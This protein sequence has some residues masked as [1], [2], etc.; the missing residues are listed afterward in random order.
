MSV[1]PRNWLTLAALLLC[2]CASVG[3][4]SLGIPGQ[5][6]IAFDEEGIEKPAEASDAS[7]AELQNFPSAMGRGAWVVRV[8]TDGEAP[9]TRWRHVE[10][11]ELLKLPADERPLFNEWL[12]H[13][14]PVVAGNAAIAL[15]RLGEGEPAQRLAATVRQPLSSLPVEQRM[16]MRCAAAEALGKVQADATV[17][18]TIRKLLAHF[19]QED[20]QVPPLQAELL[21]SLARHV[22]PDD[23]PL[24]AEALQSPKAEVQLAVI[25]CWPL[26]GRA[27]L[28]EEVAQLFST[29]DANLRSRALT[30]M[31]A[32]KDPAAFDMAQKGLSDQ[33]LEVRLAAIAA[34]GKIGTQDA[35]RQ[36]RELVTDRTERIRAEAVAALA[37]CHAWQPVLAAASDE[38][39][40]V[41]EAVAQGLAKFPPRDAQ[42]VALKLIEDQSS[43]VTARVIAAIEPWPLEQAGQVLVAAL[44]SP[45]ISVRKSAAEQLRK[46][47]EACPVFDPEASP[48]KREEQLAELQAAWTEQFAGA[49]AM[50]QSMTSEAEMLSEEASTLAA[51]ATPE[52]LAR[53]EEQLQQLADTELDAERRAEIEKQLASAGPELVAALTELRLERKMPVPESVYEHVLPQTESVFTLLERLQS[54]PLDERRRAAEELKKRI[55]AEPVGELALARLT[56][57]VV[58][59]QDAI[60]WVAIQTAL[61]ADQREP[62]VRLHQA[63]LG[64][65]AAEVRRRAC[66]YFGEHPEL[67]AEDLML[68]ALEDSNASVVQAAVEALGQS[69]AL[70]NPLP[71]VRLLISRE[72]GVRVAAAMTLA[73]LGYD[74]GHDALDR[75][76][77]DT[78][79]TVRRLAAEAMGKTKQRRYLG[80]LVRLLDDQLGVRRAALASLTEI[81]GQDIG[82]TGEEASPA[83][84]DQVVRWKS[85]YA[86]QRR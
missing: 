17:A 8:T 74:S 48:A 3:C 81:V 40:R 18:E 5:R 11:E 71:L 62:V 24:F 59:E 20:H 37:E 42:P 64:H 72:K 61:V 1:P 14:N 78:D 35:Q 67:Q 75:L 49:L 22:T 50:Q 70:R 4:H 53:V 65:P 34:L 31:A 57:L 60:V 41:R 33:T 58:P 29:G 15:A 83:L 16:A 54:T 52:T 27:K 26:E 63:A 2:A 36:L 76:A 12:D 69:S 79:P 23:E 30:L 13:K 68:Q 85:W 55:A 21:R 10:L 44:A 77:H 46:R 43:H 56:E 84:A 39:W 73:K 86:R 51:R 82:R 45:S 66:V 19:S 28:P 47:W 7:P 6:S 38:A 9:D 25:E 80:T 32:R